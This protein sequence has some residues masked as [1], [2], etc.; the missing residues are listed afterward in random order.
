MH[1]KFEESRVLGTT[2]MSRIGKKPIIIPAGITI[3]LKEGGIEVVGPKGKLDI[4]LNPKISA[5]LQGNTLTVSARQKKESD[6]L[7]G[8]YRTLIQNA[9]T[10]VTALWTK[11]LELVGVGYRAKTD[12]K[13][14]ELSLGFSHPIIFHAPKDLSYKVVENQI[15]IEGLDKYVVGEEA[16]KIR[17]VKKPEPYKGK[18]IKYKGEKIRK[19]EGKAK[20]LGGAPGA[21]K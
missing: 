11:T 9:I 1:F 7:L 4:D 15:T 13:T 19:K 18:G 8:L 3:T 6:A 17:R 2:I 16:A 5:S 14:L 10:G 21:A 12:G 20:A